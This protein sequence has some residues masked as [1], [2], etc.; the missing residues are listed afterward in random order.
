MIETNFMDECE[1]CPHLDVTKDCVGRWT[2][3]DSIW[4][5]ITCKHIEKCKTMKRYLRKEMLK[6]G[7]KEE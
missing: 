4:H 7:K 5:V 2:D 3:G 6:N 1:N